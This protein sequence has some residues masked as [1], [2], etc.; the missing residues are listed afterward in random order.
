MKKRILITSVGGIFSHDLIRS[1]RMIK[2]IFILGTDI[3]K[4]TNAYFLDK[5][6]QI[7]D[8]TKDGKQY[9]KKIIYFCKKYKINF[10][11]PCSENECIEISK[12]YERLLKLKIYTSVSKFVV[13]KTLIDKHK[14]F[15]V[16]KQNSID[17]GQWYTINNFKNLEK[18]S[19]LMGYPKTKLIIKP[20]SGSGSKGVIILNSKI[21]KF[22]YLLNDVKRFCGSGSLKAINRE[23]KRRNRNFSNYF[24]MPYYNNKTFDVDCLAK[25][26]EMKLCIPRLRTYENP[27][28]P[29]NQG[30][31]ITNDKLIINYCKKIVKAL[32][33]DGVCDFDIILRKNKKPQIIDASCRLSGSSTASLSIGLNVPLILVKLFYKEKINIKKFKKIYQVFPK[34]RF[35]LV[36]K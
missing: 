30:C 20:R 15:T 10:I 23:L 16:L 24:L 25:N 34:S 21:K 4:T 29:T 28:S 22:K 13:T 18:I 6:V 14:L 36:N 9:I 35:E 27:L 3:R 7:P 12:N 31:K 5:F 17:V 1:L 11:I 2:N 19:K 26:G 33:I 32:K 8:P